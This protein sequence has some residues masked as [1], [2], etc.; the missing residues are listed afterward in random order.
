MVSLRV[1]P[2]AGSG[3]LPGRTPSSRLP[4]R[5]RWRRYAALGFVLVIGS[6]PSLG[7]RDWP[8]PY[9][10]IDPYL[11]L[12]PGEPGA[13]VDL[14]YNH[15]VFR[16]SDHDAFQINIVG[17]AGVFPAGE[18]FAFG[19][20]YGAYLMTRPPLDGDTTGTPRL[21]W[22]MNAVQF[23]YGLHAAYDLHGK[24][25]LAEYS[26][27]SQHPLDESPG[28]GNAVTYSDYS[29]DRFAAGIAFPRVAFGRRGMITAAF[30]LGFVDMLDFWDHRRIDKPRARWL[31][32]LG[33]LATYALGDTLIG[34]NRPKLLAEAHPDL[35][36][37][38]GDDPDATLAARL[39]LRLAHVS[40][41]RVIDL[42]FDWFF[43]RD[44]EYLQDETHPV[45]LFG[46]G[47][48]IGNA[49]AQ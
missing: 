9:R 38:R 25:L 24:R 31:L 23:V 7:A 35:F 3:K 49:S 37:Q 21:D 39:G 27:A 14:E 1:F 19:V 28:E 10:T 12:Q 41:P 20:R 11:S 44:T 8:E 32:R 2:P 43:S 46:L 47:V 15:Q 29:Y 16:D 4:A 33:V 13:V 30:R 45:A 36:T 42:Y 34:G 18:R 48:R 22:M 6:G 5:R 40:T 17:G 26:R